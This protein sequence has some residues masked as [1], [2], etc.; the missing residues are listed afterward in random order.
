MP[1]NLTSTKSTIVVV[2]AVVSAV[3]VVVKRCFVIAAADVILKNIP[4]LSPKKPIKKHRW[5]LPLL[6]VVV[7]VQE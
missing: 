6:A 4:P 7:V 3:V 2:V 1:L 5:L